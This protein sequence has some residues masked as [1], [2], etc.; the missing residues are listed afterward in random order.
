MQF[1]N[2]ILL[3]I[4]QGLTEFL[5]IS[6]SGHLVLFQHFFQ[7]QTAD[8]A[9]ITLEIILHFGSLIAVLVYFRKDIWEL[10]TSL[11]HWNKNL[12][13]NKHYRNRLTILYLITA[14]FCT[15]LVYVLFG[16]RIEAMFANPLLVASMLSVTGLIVFS[17]DMVKK[18]EIPVSNM[19]LGR[20][21]IIGLG[22]GIAMIPGV[23]R[24]GT[25]IATALITGLKRSEAARFS[26]L[27]SIPA[28]L[29][30]NLSELDA[31][32][33]LKPELIASYIGGVIAAF[34]S[35]YLVIAFL[36]K[37]IQASKLKYFAFYCWFVSILSVTLILCHY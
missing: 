3:G 22:Q 4:V 13:Q 18:N 36:I 9:D 14:T 27:L 35:G 29:A 12:E 20:S 21:I 1:L 5:P 33:H 15:G 24:S 19:G 25:T 8:S 7:K 2:A 32:V 37:L 34:I 26:F 17:S 6:S 10:L 11:F 31:I 28:I 30:A 16:D 23:S